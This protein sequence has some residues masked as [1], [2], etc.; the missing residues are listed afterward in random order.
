MTPFQIFAQLLHLTP[1]GFF[2]AK[3]FLQAVLL[4]TYGQIHRPTATFIDNIDEFFVHH[5]ASRDSH[6]S[7]HG[8]LEP[9]YWYHAQLGLVSAIYLL[10]AQNPHA[11]V[12]AAIRIEAFNALRDQMPNAVN[13]LSQTSII[14]YDR[15]ALVGIF[16]RNIELERARNLAV[17]VPRTR[18]SGSSAPDRAPCATISPAIVEPVE[19]FIW[20]HT[21]ARPRDLMLIGERLAQRPARQ[22][23]PDERAAHRSR[24]RAGDL[25]PLH[26]RDCAASELVR[27]ERAVP[28]D[29]LERAVAASGSSAI[30]EDYNR[31]ALGHVPP[32]TMRTSTVHVFWDLYRA[33]L[34]GHVAGDERDGRPRQI[35]PTIAVDGHL[36]V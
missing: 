23:H 32:D 14:H 5:I 21:L 26:R 2:A 35:F 16:R 17:P 13:L 31:R 30:S 18:S 19:D 8:V 29:P 11:K 28:A 12:Y 7:Y 15:D 33:G 25:P 36:Y 34:L 20:R 9:S 27:R 22:R 24:C 1:Q 3:R 6:S 4:P 10:R